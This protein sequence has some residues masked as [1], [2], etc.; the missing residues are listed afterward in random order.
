MDCMDYME[1]S[2]YYSGFDNQY[3]LV[4]DGMRIRI[5]D[6]YSLP[7]VFSFWIY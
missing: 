1:G 6:R 7:F 3:C 5:C 4:L 2:S